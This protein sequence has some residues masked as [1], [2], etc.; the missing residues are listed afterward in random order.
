MPKL[1][2]NIKN[3]V[4]QTCEIQMSVTTM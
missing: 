1:G 4:E 2:R 3:P